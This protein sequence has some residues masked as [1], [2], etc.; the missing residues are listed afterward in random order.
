MKSRI[1][2]INFWDDNNILRNRSRF[3]SACGGLY[4][5]PSGL[6]MFACFVTESV[7]LGW[8]I[9]PFQG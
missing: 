8:S 3:L 5:A 4:F 6:L 1:F 2:R 7:A 9:L